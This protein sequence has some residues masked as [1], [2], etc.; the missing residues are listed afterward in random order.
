MIILGLNIYHGDASACI[1]KDGHLIVAAEEER[2]TRVKHSAGFP[3]AAVNFCLESLD[4][5]IDQV[6]F[7]AVNRNPK[8]RILS[9]LLY[10]F[11]NKFKIKNFVQRFYNFKKI[12]SLSSDIAQ[13]LNVD[14]Q[15]L[16]NKILFFDH[17]LCHAASSV[18]PSRSQN[19][20]YATIDGFGDF[21]ST[22]IGEYKNNQFILL[23]E[24]KFPHSLGIFYTA[25]TQFLGFENYG[26]EYK[27]MGL[28]SYGSPIYFY[29]LLKIINVDN[30][31]L[32]R[33]NLDYFKHHT[34]GIETSWLES[35]PNVASVFTNSF[36]KLFGNPRKNNEDLL[37]KHKDIASSAQAVYEFILFYIL[38]NL[39]KKTKNINLCLSGGCAMNSVANGKILKNT[40]YKNIY[41]NFA[42]SDSGGAIGAALLVLKKFNQKVNIESLNNP[43]LGNNYS[44]F[45]IKKILE[46]YKKSKKLF[47]EK[48]IINFFEDSNKKK[49]FQFIAREICNKKIIGFF[50]GKMEFGAR[51]L[52]G[53]SIIAD[54]RDPDIK[55]ILNFKIKRRESFRPFAPSILCEHM[56]EWF[57]IYDEVP[58]M[59]K[60]Y[61]VRE[62]KK[63][64]I[65]AVVHIDGTGRLQTVDGKYNKDYHCLISE[66]YNLTKIPIIL[67]TSFNENEPIVC[68]PEQAIDCFLRT[69]MDHLVLENF[70]LSRNL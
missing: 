64:L 19:T 61:K 59:S 63:K 49:L 25:V 51:A 10:F 22:T 14:T 34:S 67:N 69:K 44:N 42:P 33:L 26:D 38:N 57:D 54:P 36:C 37:Q 8:L 56:N 13:R 31:N 70:V 28:A 65:P 41:I 5:G 30:K 2:F 62:D 7:I 18:F 3:I 46:I 17:H 55:K 6:D 1:F 24:V 23:D 43:Y 48:I 16:K 9:K 40:N 52:G 47:N 12:T 4:I 53:R 45:E 68:N 21:L 60:V 32:F 39:Q 58:F 29:H 27:V 15:S 50:N 11:K 35:N 20:D 66:F